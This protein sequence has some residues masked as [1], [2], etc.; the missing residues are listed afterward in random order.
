MAGWG[1]VFR[2]PW[3]SGQN[4]QRYV[5]EP[6]SSGIGGGAFALVAGP[7]G[8]TSF[9][10]RETA[11]A[12]ATPEMFLEGGEPLPFL[13]AVASGD[14]VGVPGLVRLIETL[15]KRY[16]KLP[17]AALFEPA[18]KL[19]KSAN[20]PIH[21]VTLGTD[22]PPRNLRIADVQLPARAFKDDELEVVAAQ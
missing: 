1:T 8:V 2:A 15:H 10:A 12:A 7:E 18:I 16:G 6:Q 20:I 9:D 14:S 4:N 22:R 11:P 13:A 19:A 5:V 17:W 3:P 21:A